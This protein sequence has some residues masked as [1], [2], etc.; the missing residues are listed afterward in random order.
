MRGAL[1]HHSAAHAVE[2]MPQSDTEAILLGALS[3]VGETV[4]VRL[5]DGAEHRVASGYQAKRGAAR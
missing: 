1:S 2:V 4:R 5:V 3:N